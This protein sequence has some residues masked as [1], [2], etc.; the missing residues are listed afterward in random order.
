M[1][2]KS[3]GSEPTCP[4]FK[5]LWRDLGPKRERLT[6]EMIARDATDFNL[7]RAYHVWRQWVDWGEQDGRAL[8]TDALSTERIC[9]GESML[10]PFCGQPMV[11]RY[12][13]G[14]GYW[15]C[16]REP[17]CK[18][19]T[20]PGDDVQALN[21]LEFTLPD[22]WTKHK[23]EAKREAQEEKK[24]EK[25]GKKKSSAPKFKLLS[26]SKYE[27]ASMKGLVE[28]E[29][30]LVC[31]CDPATGCHDECVNRLLFIECIPETCP[32][33][34]TSKACGNMVIQRSE[35][36]KTEVFETADCRGWALR[37]KEDVAEGTML[38]EY[39][40]EVI[41]KEE[42]MNRLRLTAARG[43]HDVYI[44][45]LDAEHFLDAKF[46]GGVARF[47]NH[48][49]GPNSQMQKWNV[50]GETRV[51]LA[52]GRDLFAGE[53]IT[54]NYQMD[55][56][57][58]SITRQRCLCGAPACAGYIGGRV[59]S[60][61][62][63]GWFAR[64]WR[65]LGFPANVVSPIIDID[66]CVLPRESLNAAT[67]A[68]KADT[69]AVDMAVEEVA[70]AD[71]SKPAKGQR[72]GRKRAKTSFFEAGA[73]SGASS[74]SPSGK[75]AAKGMGGR[76]GKNGRFQGYQQ[77]P[78]DLTTGQ[79]VQAH[80]PCKYLVFKGDKGFAVEKTGEVQQ[81]STSEEAAGVAEESQTK[82]Q[83]KIKMKALQRQMNKV[84]I[85][86]VQLLYDD[87]KPRAGFV[88]LRKDLNRTDGCGGEEEEV[89][90][91]EAGQAPEKEAEVVVKKGKSR[92]RA[93]AV[94]AASASSSASDPTKSGAVTSSHPRVYLAVKRSLI[95]IPLTDLIV[96]DNAAPVPRGYTKL[97]QRLNPQRDDD[98]CD[99]D[100]EASKSIAPLYLAFRLGINGC[101]ATMNPAAPTCGVAELHTLLAESAELGVPEHAPALRHV[102]DKVLVG[103][104]FN[105]VV[106]K[107]LTIEP[108]G[109]GFVVRS[110]EAAD[111]VLQ[112]AKEEAPGLRI[113]SVSM[114]RQM[115]Q[116]VEQTNAMVAKFVAQQQQKDQQQQPEPESMDT[117]AA[118]PVAVSVLGAGLAFEP[119][120]PVLPEEMTSVLQPPS[121]PRPQLQ[122]VLEWLQAADECRP[123]E[124]TGTEEL[125]AMVAAADSWVS[126]AQRVILGGSPK[127]ASGDPDDGALEAALEELLFL[128]WGPRAL[129][130]AQAAR[131][132]C[133]L[134][135]SL[136]T[137]AIATSSAAGGLLQAK[138]LKVVGADDEDRAPTPALE[139]GVGVDVTHSPQDTTGK[140]K[141]SP[142][143]RERDDGGKAKKGRGKKKAAGKKGGEGEGDG[144]QSWVALQATGRYSLLAPTLPG[145]APVVPISDEQLRLLDGA[146]VVCANCPAVCSFGALGID[147]SNETAAIAALR[148]SAKPTAGTTASTSSFCCPSCLQLLGLPSSLV[149]SS[150]PPKPST[151]KI[152]APTAT[153][154]A[155]DD[156]QPDA[157]AGALTGAPSLPAL[158][159]LLASA[160]KL[161]VTG[162]EAV[163]LVEF[164]VAG[165]EGWRKRAAA[166]VEAYSTIDARTSSGGSA[167]MGRLASAA[168]V[169]HLSM[170]LVERAC[171]EV[172]SSDAGGDVERQVKAALWSIV[173]ANIPAVL[174]E[175]FALDGA[176]DT[177]PACRLPLGIAG[178]ADDDDGM[179]SAMRGWGAS[180]WNGKA[181]YR[182]R[183]NETPAQVAQRA[184]VA[185]A[186]LLE[187][188]SSFCPGLRP[189]A[190]LKPNTLLWVSH[191]R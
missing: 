182:A 44:A 113:D 64:A 11:R 38:C 190:K 119:E 122:H 76:G 104:R 84:P 50:R 36:A 49:C 67:K 140:R 105:E 2:D 14:G 160:R 71:T 148:K 130:A 65:L 188:N 109:M 10:Q 150:F 75:T 35:F 31:G 33:A 15:C 93:K 89:E 137:N 116:R 5:K 22:E 128:R 72:K 145:N 153:D 168:H 172:D 115:L 18:V 110:R 167:E 139:A 179:A 103:E 69:D 24:Q 164:L 6:G 41:T 56:I 131:A 171:I 166:A 9:C 28:N 132:R 136:G 25:A 100:G 177:P 48:S 46:M 42:C 96:L 30:C 154:D 134:L 141:A 27:S 121:D 86:G 161:P 189:S 63:L 156:P 183:N 120:L 157:H 53:E 4:A 99:D 133:R 135:Q 126:E 23:R 158:R 59:Q 180:E 20:N 187:L 78:M 66:L 90:A 178:S 91:D 57:G 95:D 19:K 13:M 32:C 81:S 191:S 45:S 39:T 111:A 117:D 26:K 125:R 17:Y 146:S 3:S 68:I 101:V 37:V 107:L 47:A 29:E 114:L 82:Q 87:E 85:V 144:V 106:D 149:L 79:N 61:K 16:P 169:Q 170:L 62:T 155:E 1:N 60:N 127:G 92:G 52:A 186:R 97:A 123:F 77:L 163:D 70:E 152:T 7:P 51:V 129:S 102:R 74:P 165:V 83:Q 118:S 58:G 174:K 124:V 12:S 162:L 55:T 176:S 185:V 94:A 143:K 184:G 34:K 43:E 80:T 98:D 108:K 175:A 142:L 138:R 73:A 112:R 147:G 54:Y 151:A 159:A 181:W 21:G 173:G 8:D 88:K 40:G